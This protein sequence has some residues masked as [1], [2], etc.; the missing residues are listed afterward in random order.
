M[1]ILALPPAYS[2]ICSPAH[3]QR[4]DFTNAPS[5]TVRWYASHT[6]KV[7]SCEVS[8]WLLPF[9]VLKA[10]LGCCEL[11]NCSKL[12]WPEASWRSFLFLDTSWE[13]EEQGRAVSKHFLPAGT[14]HLPVAFFFTFPLRR[15]LPPH[16]HQE[17]N[18][19]QH[20]KEQEMFSELLWTPTPLSRIRDGW[21]S[22]W[23]KFTALEEKRVKERW[24]KKWTRDTLLQQDTCQR[25]RGPL[26]QQSPGI[27]RSRFPQWPKQVPLSAQ[28][29][30]LLPSKPGTSLRGHVYGPVSN[31]RQAVLCTLLSHWGL[32]SLTSSP[33]FSVCLKGSKFL[34][35]YKKNACGLSPMQ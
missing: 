20:R 4:Q 12:S 32:Y 28:H 31:S 26:L 35:V 33:R 15:A 1:I 27:H 3:S 29:P 22:C 13:K 23:E 21:T 17:T 10:I 34:V 7:C 5:Y 25:A 9:W 6:N 19:D 2:C 16:P 24:I 8:V 30:A 18:P 14:I 11:Q